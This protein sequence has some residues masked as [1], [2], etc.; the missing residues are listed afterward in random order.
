M[1]D[2]TLTVV[3]EIDVNATSN[4]SFK[5]VCGFIVIGIPLLSIAAYAGSVMARPPA[6]AKKLALNSK[7]ADK[8]T[9]GSVSPKPEMACTAGKI[10]IRQRS[11]KF[12]FSFAL[13]ASMGP[14]EEPVP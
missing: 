14:A 5:V 10:D 1:G 7:V 3:T 4:S 9:T 2:G 6:I 12:D 11:S 8:L 13:G